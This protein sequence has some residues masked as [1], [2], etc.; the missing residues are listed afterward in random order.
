MGRPRKYASFEEAT[1]ERNARRRRQ[2]G[3]ASANDNSREC[4]DTAARTRLSVPIEQP[5]S[6]PSSVEFSYKGSVGI[7]TEGINNRDGHRVGS[8]YLRSNGSSISH[9][10]NKRTGQDCA[11][12]SVRRMHGYVEES[13]AESTALPSTSAS[14]IA[15][16]S[17]DGCSGPIIADG[18]ALSTPTSK[19]C[20]SVRRSDA[21]QG[22]RKML[23]MDPLSMV[24]TEPD[25]LPNI[26]DC[27]YCKAKKFQFEPPGFCCSSGEI[28]LLPTEMPRELMML[29]L[30]DSEEAIEF[31]KCVGIKV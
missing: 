3:N 30:E 14:N 11:E 1:R 9:V 8:T 20:R 4:R 22:R 23:A 5:S 25:I 26:S 6:S 31:R 21:G 17:R 13:H 29:Y 19:K 24:A 15:G 18:G 10:D 2:R 27:Q 7:N 12:T 28:Q 16:Y